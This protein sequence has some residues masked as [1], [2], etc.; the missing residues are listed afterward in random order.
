MIIPD[1]GDGNEPQ[2]EQTQPEP[3]KELIIPDSGDGN[4]FAE[5]FSCEQVGRN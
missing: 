5:S 1:S 4:C 2:P 3:L